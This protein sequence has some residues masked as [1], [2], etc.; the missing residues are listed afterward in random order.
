VR[1]CVE[2]GESLSLDNVSPAAQPFLAVLLSSLLPGRPVVVVTDNLKTQEVFQQDIQTWLANL[3]DAAGPGTV[4]EAGALFYPSWEVLPHEARLPH[5][6]V[7]SDRLETLV[8]LAQDLTAPKTAQRE[9]RP[10]VM[11]HSRIIVTSVNALLE[12]PHAAT[13]KGRSHRTAGFD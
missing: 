12:R 2:K 8:A 4:G 9:L 11:C 13:A 10:A 3:P 5:V 7:I 1:E 6:D